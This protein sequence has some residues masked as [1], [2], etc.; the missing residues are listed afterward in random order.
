MDVPRPSWAS[1]GFLAFAAASLLFTALSQP[2]WIFNVSAFVVAL[3]SIAWFFRLRLISSESRKAASFSR[4]QGLH[5]LVVLFLCITAVLWRNLTWVDPPTEGELRACRGMATV[6]QA[7]N[8]L[9]SFDSTADGTIDIR[10]ERLRLRTAL[11]EALTN[12]GRDAVDSGN[13]SLQVQGSA[14]LS[15][16]AARNAAE[17]FSASYI[18]AAYRAFEAAKKVAVICLEETPD[19]AHG[20]AGIGRRS[21]DRAGDWRNQSLCTKAALVQT[22]IFAAL[23]D[24][25]EST[26]ISDELDDSLEFVMDAAL[27]NLGVLWNSALDERPSRAVLENISNMYALEEQDPEAQTKAFVGLAQISHACQQANA[28]PTAPGDVAGDGSALSHSS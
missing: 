9:V 6:L 15:S 23:K 3:V 5:L 21:K 25:R 12:S 19:V 11:D 17:R 24:P 27:A 28:Y 14:I 1:V 22:Q 16:M 7:A 2:P 8:G 18:D 13:D 26:L 4:R 20:F 10:P